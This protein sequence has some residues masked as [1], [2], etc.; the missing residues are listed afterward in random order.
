MKE[1]YLIEYNNDIRKLPLLI[2]LKNII[3]YD[4]LVHLS[5][6]CI[7]TEQALAPMSV[8]SWCRAPVN[9]SLWIPHGPWG[10]VSDQYYHWDA[11]PHLGQIIPTM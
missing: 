5:H 3:E 7:S 11:A 2:S 9:C 1:L 10:T 4:E 8:I 6:I